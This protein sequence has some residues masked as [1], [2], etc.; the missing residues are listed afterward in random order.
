M[1][2]RLLVS[3]S[4]SVAPSHGGDGHG[5]SRLAHRRGWDAARR[6][7]TVSLVIGATLL[8]ALIAAAALA[9]VL[10]D[11]DPLATDAAALELPPG[12]AGHPLGTDSLGRDLLARVLYGGRVSLTVG[13]LA[14]ALSLLLGVVVGAAAGMSSPRLDAL[15]MRT[16]DALLA[17]PLLVVIIAVQAITQPSLASVVLV[18][19]ATSWMPVT[20]V[21]RAEF[22]S[23]RERDYVRAAI[24]VGT[25]RWKVAARHILPNALPPVLVLAALQVSHAVIAESTLSFLGLGVPPHQPTWGNMLTAAQQHVLSGQWWTLVWPGAAIVLTILSINL[26]ADGVRLR[27]DPHARRSG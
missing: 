23:L 4:P 13:V 1:L 11:R 14:T 5:D 27:G 18:I 24:S 21:V 9:P 3:V 10:T 12:A 26:I 15:L 17:L 19:A 8:L 22:L 25:S 6:P 7:G 2:R 20:R 16:V